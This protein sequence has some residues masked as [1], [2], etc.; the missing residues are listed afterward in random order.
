MML[1]D[2]G[3]EYYRYGSDITA[4]FPANG[5]FSPVQAAVYEAVLAA[6]ES[7]LGAMRPGVSWPVRSPP[8]CQSVVL[9]SMLPVACLFDQ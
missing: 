8:T 7:V 4:S 6:F 1:L 2:I 9:R 5:R 3:C